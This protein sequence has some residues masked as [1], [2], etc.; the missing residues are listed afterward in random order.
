MPPAHG[1][2]VYVTGNFLLELGS[3]ASLLWEGKGRLRPGVLKCT[4][5]ADRR[6]QGSAGL[7]WGHWL[8]YTYT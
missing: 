6:N 7:S 4:V 2:Y 5:E 8:I 3:L 1:Y